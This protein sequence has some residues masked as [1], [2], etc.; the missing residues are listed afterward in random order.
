[1][2]ANGLIFKVN[3]IFDIKYYHFRKRWYTRLCYWRV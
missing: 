2:F 1:V 3:L